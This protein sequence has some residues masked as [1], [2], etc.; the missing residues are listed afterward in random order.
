M[1]RV[2][3]V[4]SPAPWDAPCAARWR[5]RRRRPP[6]TPSAPPLDTDGSTASVDDAASDYD[7]MDPNKLTIF[8]YSADVPPKSVKW[9]PTF[10]IFT[11]FTILHNF[12]HFT[13]FSLFLHNFHNFTPFSPFP[14]H[15]T[16]FPTIVSISQPF[17]LIPTIDPGHPYGRCH[18]ADAPPPRLVMPPLIAIRLAHLAAHPDP[19]AGRFRCVRSEFL[20]FCANSI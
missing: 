9:L 18:T 3:Q 11:I 6:G 2:E 16:H 20:R 8:H 15:F 4:P 13:Q 19:L 7:A 14:H 17:N 1:E 12:H 5:S 10:T